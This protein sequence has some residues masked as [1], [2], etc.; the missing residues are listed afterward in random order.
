MR[1]IDVERIKKVRK[2]YACAKDIELKK[3]IQKNF[4]KFTIT[5]KKELAVV[6]YE[7]GT[8]G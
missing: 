4:K 8:F 3:N 5:V 1:S 6:R 2:P 7:A